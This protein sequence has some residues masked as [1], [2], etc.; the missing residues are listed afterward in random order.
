MG[1]PR[2]VNVL[3]PETRSGIPSPHKTPSPQDYVVPTD[4]INFRKK[5]VSVQSKQERFF[6][7]TN[8]PKIKASVPVQYTAVDGLSSS[9]LGVNTP[10][11]T[12]KG[13]IGGRDASKYR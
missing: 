1:A 8:M 3:N 9:A 12:V 4:N 5:R 10:V 11:H 13:Y 2:H 6:T 7:P